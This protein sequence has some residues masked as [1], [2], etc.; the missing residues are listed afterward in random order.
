MH[1]PM[2]VLSHQAAL[3]TQPSCRL[4]L[5]GCRF[6]DSLAFYSMTKHVDLY[7]PEVLPEQLFRWLL[8]LKWRPLVFIWYAGQDPLASPALWCTCLWKVR[9]PVSTL[10]DVAKAIH[11]SSAVHGETVR[12]VPSIQCSDSTGVQHVQ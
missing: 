7:G 8:L 9:L 5:H 11:L 2:A 4:S 3:W 10:Q 1:S 6:F 12:T